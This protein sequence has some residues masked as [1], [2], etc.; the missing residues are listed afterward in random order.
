MGS[1]VVSGVLVMPYAPRRFG[2]RDGTRL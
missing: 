2:A 1:V